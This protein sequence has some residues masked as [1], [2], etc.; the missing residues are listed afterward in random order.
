MCRSRGDFS[1][2]DPD[3]PM[4]TAMRQM[5]GV[6]AQ[7][8]RAMIAK[9]LRDG[10]RHKSDLGGY[11]HGAPPDGYRAEGRALVPDPGEQETL[12]RIRQF[13]AEGA[14]LREIARALTNEGRRPRRGER[15]CLFRDA[16]ASFNAERLW[17]TLADPR[18]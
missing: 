6:F 13:R 17:L 7:L 15:W 10:R 4:R 9:R 3:D 18:E 14:S 11:G 5:V 16:P 8:E 12:S 2:D 1:K